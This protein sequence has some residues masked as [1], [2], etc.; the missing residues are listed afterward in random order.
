MRDEGGMKN[1]CSLLVIEIGPPHHNAYTGLKQLDRSKHLS[2]S[3]TKGNVDIET[4]HAFDEQ[5]NVVYYTE[6]TSTI[7]GAKFLA[8]SKLRNPSRSISILYLPATVADI[9]HQV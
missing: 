3:I 2:L 1:H 8:S 9:N 7:E 6:A 5:R 4:I